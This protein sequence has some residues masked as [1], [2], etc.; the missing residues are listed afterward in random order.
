MAKGRGERERGKGGLIGRVRERKRGEWGEGKGGGKEGDRNDRK[1][2]TAAL[3]HFSIMIKQKT[4]T[5]SK[6][7]AL[8]SM[9]QLDERKEYRTFSD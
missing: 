3:A 7:D 4:N 5:T 8:K 1:G 6:W 9:G 2:A